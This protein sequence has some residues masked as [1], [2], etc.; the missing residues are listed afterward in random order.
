MERQIVLDERSFKALSA[1]SRVSILK[2]LGERRRTLSELSQKLDL[3]NSTVKEHCDILIQAQLI[4]Q[5]DEGRKWKYYELTQKGKQI[6]LPNLME[7]VKVL[8]ILCIGVIMVGAVAF[9][10]L[11][12]TSGIGASSAS[13]PMA[14]NSESGTLLSKSNGIADINA[15]AENTAGTPQRCAESVARCS[16]SAT[17]GITPEFF[18]LSAM[19]SI[20]FGVVLGWAITRR[21]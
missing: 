7:E 14:I 18:I 17:G 16:I 5:I 15:L 11:Q 4:K 19:I 9:F 8:I 20:I 3:G 13:A 10:A 21:S 12:M 2:S 1:D 6:V